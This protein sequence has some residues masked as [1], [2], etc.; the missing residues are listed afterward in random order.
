[1]LTPGNV[2]AGYRIEQILGQGGMGVVYEATQLALHR[3]VALKF[4]SANFLNDVDFRERFRREGVI[5]AAID[6]PHIVP[7]YEAGEVPEGLFLAMRLVRGPNLKELI[8][9]GELDP[10]RA[11]AILEQVAD[12]LDAAHAAGLTHR[13]IKPQNILVGQR[14]HGYLADFGLTKGSDVSSITRTGQFLGTLDYVAPEQI[15]G[16]VATARSDIYSLTAVLYECLT[17]SV[18]Y[19]RPSEAAVLFAHVS[20]PPPRVSEKRPDL[21][22][23]LDE[24]I[25]RGMCKPSADRPDSARIVVAAAAAALGSHV[26]IA[27]APVPVTNGGRAPTTVPKPTELEIEPPVPTTEL[28]IETPPA[29]TE[30]DIEPAPTTTEFDVTP[31]ASTELDVSPRAS[32]TELD[33]PEPS[34]TSPE[35][36]PSST[37]TLDVDTAPSP[38]D[39]ATTLPVAIEDTAT[40]DEAV[41]PPPPTAASER[42][43]PTKPDSAVR[44][45][46][47]AAL[48]AGVAAGVVGI[49]VGGATG[50]AGEKPAPPRQEQPPVTAS[51]SGLALTAPGGWRRADADTRAIP[52]MTFA[53]PVA[54]TD[55]DDRTVI[56]GLVQSGDPSL[57]ADGLRKRLG[58]VPPRDESVRLGDAAAYRY[59]DLSLTGFDRRVELMVVP[60]TAGVATVACLAPADEARAFAAACENVARSLEL[61]GPRPYPLG[62]DP[63]FAER[64]NKAMRALNRERADARRDLAAAKRP[65]GQAEQATRLGADFRTAAAAI[66]KGAVSPAV[67]DDRA[68]IVRAMRDVAPE[69]RAL[70]SSANRYEKGD[71]AAA[72]KAIRKAEAKVDRSLSALRTEGY[73]VG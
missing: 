36:P 40:T 7:V 5:Q 64:L 41:P 50:G 60:T 4:L 28:D 30:M 49:L 59:A 58:G 44:R 48:V 13:D 67:A 57:L 70:A 25:A 61:D 53:D 29:T 65:S 69:Y 20:D 54:V 46:R 32:T 6:H 19:P 33:V 35:L 62:P 27:S 3:T 31:V 26:S 12:A 43:P 39:D 15:N 37:T 38:N 16:E 52:G 68:A 10:A 14:D 9:R 18:P 1:M 8:V 56:A 73:R 47:I 34:T 72:R 11:V 71:F 42:R 24:V 45:R 66:G 51:A 22:A 2:I 21:P 23:G 63:A 17:G 55:G